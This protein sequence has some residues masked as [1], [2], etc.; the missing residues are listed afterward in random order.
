MKSSRN[1]SNLKRIMLTHMAEH[2]LLGK[3]DRELDRLPIRMAEEMKKTYRC[4]KYRDRAV[5]K[6]RLM[7]G[8][9]MAAEKEVDE[10]TPP[11]E[12]LA[13]AKS[14]VKTGKRPE[15]ETLTVISE[16]CSSCP[17]GG[18]HI[19]DICRGCVARPC[20]TSCPVNAV[21]II[22]GRSVIDK[23]RCIQC[24]K[25]A[26]ECPYG[27][28][29]KLPVPCEDAC[30]VAAITKNENGREG[31]NFEICISCGKCMTACPFGAVADISHLADVLLQIKNNK[32]ITALYA[33]SVAGQ[34]PGSLEQI[35][36][37]IVLAGFSS[38]YEV[39][40]GAD[41]TT[42]LEGRELTE[43]IGEGAP[44]MTTSCCPAFVE[45]VK[46][47]VPDMAGLLS[48][49][50]S[51]MMLTAELAKEEYPETLT[52]FIGPCTAKKVE[53]AKSGMIDYVLTFEELGAIFL[54]AGVDTTQI[55]ENKQA[56]S[57]KGPRAHREGR[58][59]GVSKGVAT[60]VM[61]NIKSNLDIKPVCI[62]GLDKKQIKL[63]K[64]YAKGK[65]PGN[66]MEVMACEGGCINGPGTI[67]PTAVAQQKT[68]E[69]VQQAKPISSVPK[70]KTC[71]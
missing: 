65:A 9:G 40:S 47:H 12:Y 51:P 34:F 19:S 48:A 15:G 56:N 13:M 24:G 30:P 43:R 67:C 71:I 16:A 37:G 64:A 54:A 62:N 44:L 22:G 39:A 45:T 57:A 50:P 59:F 17:G 46:K 5:L 11:S 25:C 68:L 58:G 49:T 18:Y 21:S 41:K 36:R 2:I 55:E 61:Q 1:T 52:V 32:H 7:A 38:V 35:N 33:P 53:A 26:K 14:R 66:F 27:A 20:E 6:Y 42:V 23:E 28:I 70:V 10:L 69:F 4:C 60:A 29:L 31:I 63:L 8:L 3:E